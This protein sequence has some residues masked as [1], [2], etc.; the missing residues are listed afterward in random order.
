MSQ[1]D[2]VDVSTTARTESG[3]QIRWKMLVIAVGTSALIAGLAAWATLNAGLSSPVFVVTLLAATYVLYQK[4]LPY[5]V[6]GLGLNVA[7]GVV[8]LAPFVFYLSNVFGGQSD[9]V[10]G[11][12]VMIESLWGLATWGVVSLILAVVV[13]SVACYFNVEA[14]KKKR[15]W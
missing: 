2:V 5:E 8:F 4:E 10:P 13:G 9:A 7:A 12:G 1:D 15:S 6:L 14:R 3:R 11:T